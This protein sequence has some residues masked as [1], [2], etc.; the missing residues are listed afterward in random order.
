MKFLFIVLMLLSGIN[1]QVFAQKNEI[2]TQALNNFEMPAGS[3]SR[4]FMISLGKGNRIQ[5]ELGNINDLH[6]MENIDSILRVFTDD[7]E[8]LQEKT[9]NETN[10][11]RIDYIQDSSSVNRIKITSTAPVG[12]SYIVK[13]TAAAL[14]KL[15]QDSIFIVG[16]TSGMDNHS[17]FWRRYFRI[18]IFIN[19]LDELPGYLDGRLRKKIMGLENTHTSDWEKKKAGPV[20]LK[21]DHTISAQHIKGYVTGKDYILFRYSADIQN[22]K[23]YFVPSATLGLSVFRYNGSYFREYGFNTEY[24]FSFLKNAQGNTETGVNLFL[25]VSYGINK[26]DLPSKYFA[27][28]KWYGSAGVLVNRQGALFDKNTFRLGAGRLSLFNGSTQIEPV[29]YIHDLFKDLSPGIRLKQSF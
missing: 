19:S 6:Y 7:M 15:T 26:T 17:Q 27:V 29:L 10:S 14:L 2:S 13:K 22:Y 25:S 16:S 28:F 24:H 1:S 8:T 21:T 18:S 11:R 20:Y 23:N 5:L 12:N 3:I 4:V 9:G